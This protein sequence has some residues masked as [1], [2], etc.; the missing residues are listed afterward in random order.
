[1]EQNSK[2][3]TEKIEAENSTSQENQKPSQSQKQNTYSHSEMLTPS[4]IESLRK[5]RKESAL[6][7]RAYFTAKY[8]NPN[9]N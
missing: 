6:V 8:G 2:Q 4:E 7:S 9:Q 3:E 5:D 1:M